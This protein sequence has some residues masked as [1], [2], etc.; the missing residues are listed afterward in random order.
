MTHCCNAGDLRIGYD[1]A[2]VVS[3]PVDCCDY[4]LERLDLLEIRLRDDRASVRHGP[5]EPLLKKS[6]DGL[7]DWGA[8]YAELLA[9]FPL[10]ET[11]SRRQGTGD[12]HVPENG[13]SRAI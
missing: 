1:L 12:D 9:E 3:Q 11:L 10:A 4:D 5:D 13:R 8:A 2:G 7:S 6:L